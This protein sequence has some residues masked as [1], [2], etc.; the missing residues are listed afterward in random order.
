M[1]IF[2][3]F[4]ISLSFSF[5]SKPSVENLKLRY[6]YQNKEIQLKKLFPS[7]KKLLLLV[8]KDCAYCLKQLFKLDKCPQ[9]NM[10]VVSKNG[11]KRKLK[12]KFFPFKDKIPLFLAISALPEFMEK[13][14]SP[15][16]IYLDSDG[17][18][19]K[20]YSGVRDCKDFQ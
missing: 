11:S 2:L 16:F 5:A 20:Q 10:L 15:S 13:L 6:L 18:I 1:K 14:P 3:P 12:R 9:K 4:L 19:G 17:R 7:K 8:E